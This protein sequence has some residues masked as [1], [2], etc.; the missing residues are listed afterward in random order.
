LTGRGLNGLT[1][2]DDLE[3]PLAMDDEERQQSLT[4][5]SFGIFKRIGFGQT[6]AFNALILLQTLLQLSIT[7]RFMEKGFPL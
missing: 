5:G 2:L 1:S 4:H 3:S 6:R 7:G